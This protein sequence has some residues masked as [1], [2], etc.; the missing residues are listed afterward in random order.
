MNIGKAIAS[1]RFRPDVVAGGSFEPVA[2][3]RTASP[4]LTDSIS[5]LLR[6]LS[7]RDPYSGRHSTRVTDLAVR[8]ARFLCL[9]ADDLLALRT[10]VYLHD[11]GKI[12]ISDAILLKPGPLTP[13]EREHIHAH[14][15]IGYK[16]IEPLGLTAREKEIIL[17]HHER[18]DGQGYPLGLSG[19]EIP[20]LAR[21]TALADVYDALVTDRPYRGRFTP[22]AAVKEIALQ[23]GRQFDPDLTREFLE[24]ISAGLSQI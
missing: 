5:A 11:I 2:A 16:I 10:A 22:R 20:F 19:E 13:E 6:T 3:R 4:Q 1:N 9:P 14:P 24:F 17:C 8:F 23:S 7:A 12:G 21:L 15:L 18:W